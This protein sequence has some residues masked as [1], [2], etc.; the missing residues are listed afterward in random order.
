MSLRKKIDCSIINVFPVVQMS[1]CPM[2]VW[3][4]MTEL[5]LPES[6]TAL[7]LLSLKRGTESDISKNERVITQFMA[8]KGKL[9]DSQGVYEYCLWFY[10]G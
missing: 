6:T 4:A 5:P 8:I 10:P 2:S 1:V 7:P 9:A 3:M